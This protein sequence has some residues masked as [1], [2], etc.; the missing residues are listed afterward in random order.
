MSRGQKGIGM[1]FFDVDGV[2]F[3]VPEYEESGEKVAVS[4]WNAIFDKLGIYH[5]HERLKEMFISGRFPSYMEWTDEACKVLQ[6]HGLTRK[7]FM[8]VINGR[9]PMRGAGEALQELKRRGYKTA[10]ITGSFKALAM[11]AQKLFGIDHVVAHC[12]LIF[13]KNGKLEG[14]K[15]TPCDYQEKALYF[16]EIAKK[17]GLSPSQCAYVGDDV[18]DIP[19]FREAGFTISFNSRKGSVKKAAHVVIDEKDLRKILP[20]FPPL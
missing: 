14:W 7:I 2:L 4:T 8:E 17:F 10:V 18:N 9:P 13:G 6:Q 19:I 12:E 16:K 5:E 11:R 15:L 3:D 1:V 20:Y